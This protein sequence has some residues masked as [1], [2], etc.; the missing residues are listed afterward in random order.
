[1]TNKCPVS[2]LGYTVMLYIA[3]N[4]GITIS[5]HSG[6]ANLSTYIYTQWVVLRNTG[7]GGDRAELWQCAII[8]TVLVCV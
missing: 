5:K 6:Y 3:V 8:H 7:L 2:L 1:M 4:L